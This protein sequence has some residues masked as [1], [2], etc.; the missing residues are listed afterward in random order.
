MMVCVVDAELVESSRRRQETEAWRA[1]QQQQQKSG[2]AGRL[3][4]SL[5]D[6]HI[7]SRSGDIRD[8][9]Y[10]PPVRALWD[11]LEAPTRDGDPGAGLE[12]QERAI[13]ENLEREEREQKQDD[14]IDPWKVHNLKPRRVRN[15]KL[16]NGDVDTAE[17]GS[18][19]QTRTSSSRV[20]EER[21]TKTR[22]GKTESHVTRETE[23]EVTSGHGADA[24]GLGNEISA[25][26][27]AWKSMEALEGRAREIL[28]QVSRDAEWTPPEVHSS[29]RW[30]D[31]DS[32]KRRMEEF[33]TEQAKLR[34]VRAAAEHAPCVA[35]KA[36]RIM[37][38]FVVLRLD[39][40][41]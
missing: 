8:D 19:I 31:L 34:Q 4:T 26:L 6:V 5:G 33:D 10:K 7:S 39:V 30:F 21:V 9:V 1:L 28:A 27:K 36:K 12:A 17:S 14:Y 3:V 15:G 24:T 35:T 32:E 2:D 20:V 11:R 13:I 16:L 29:W 23:T 41:A 38:S 25:K 22:G 18:E 40:W 37:C